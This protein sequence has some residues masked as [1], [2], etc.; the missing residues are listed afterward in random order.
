MGY[1]QTL[2]KEFFE[3]FPNQTFTLYSGAFKTSLSGLYKD[4]EF[5]LDNQLQTKT[6]E[7][8]ISEVEEK[9]KAAAD[10]FDD[11]KTIRSIKNLYTAIKDGA[12]AIK[13]IGGRE[14]LSPWL[15]WQKVIAHNH[16][17]ITLNFIVTNNIKKTA[18][19]LNLI[20]LQSINKNTFLWEY[21]PTDGVSQ[22][23]K[24]ATPLSSKLKSNANTKKVGGELEKL[25]KGKLFRLTMG[26]WFDSGYQL[27][28]SG[29]NFRI[30]TSVFDEK[31]NPEYLEVTLRLKPARQIGATDYQKWFKL[32]N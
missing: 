21:K 13:S 26:N 18:D 6:I 22:F 30:K 7:E 2:P 3:Y 1:I 17:F 32:T 11:N 27:L 12:S 5:S 10:N 15:S 29:C 14:N 16:G 20:S 24:S 31:G 23:L 8:I 25:M 4:E 19:F 28:V 9:M